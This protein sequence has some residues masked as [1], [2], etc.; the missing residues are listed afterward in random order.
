MLMDGSSLGRLEPGQ[1]FPAEAEVEALLVERL[2]APGFVAVCTSAQS[3]DRVVSLYRACKRT[4]RTFVLD[5]YAA[6]ALAATGNPNTP[7]AGWSHV[8]IYVPRYQ[9]RHVAR[10]ER[11]DLLGPYKAHR[12][13][14]EELA[15][16]ASR[17][18][19]LFR[20]AMLP[21]V[22]ALGTAWTG[23]RAIWSRCMPLR[24]TDLPPCSART[25]SG[26]RTENGGRF[27]GGNV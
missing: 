5:F 13:Y 14:P 12:I 22:D 7:R 16:L 9:R 18:A 21:G 26:G 20:P 10:T 19:M 15:A 4:G 6:E 11:F 3:A 2:R 8:A 17:A 24:A 27:D 1:R 25:W 23:A